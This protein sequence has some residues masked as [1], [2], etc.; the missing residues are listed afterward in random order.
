MNP[1]ARRKSFP[2]LE[3]SRLGRHG[4]AD[5]RTTAFAFCIR[6]RKNAWEL[7]EFFNYATP[8]VIMLSL[9][10]FQFTMLFTS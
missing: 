7:R 8:L 4:T 3:T 2:C 1:R 10:M 9:Y 6:F 5:E